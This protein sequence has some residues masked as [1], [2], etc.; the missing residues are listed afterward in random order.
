MRKSAIVKANAKPRRHRQLREQ[1]PQ[2]SQSIARMTPVMLQSSQ[3]NCCNPDARVEQ[4]RFPLFCQAA[5]VPIALL[6]T[7]RWWDGTQSK[8]PALG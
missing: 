4:E 5:V 2:H 8:K 1:Q 3:L 6:K 7:W